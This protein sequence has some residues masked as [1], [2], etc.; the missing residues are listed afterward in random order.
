MA[1]SVAEIEQFTHAMPDFR[2]FWLQGSSPGGTIMMYGTTGF[3][4]AG[5][6]IPV[7]EWTVE[8]LPVISTIGELK[9]PQPWDMLNGSVT[10]AYNVRTGFPPGVTQ[11]DAWVGTTFHVWRIGDELRWAAGSSLI[12]LTSVMRHALTGFSVHGT[13]VPLS[14]TLSLFRSSAT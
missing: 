4:P 13:S 2:S 5:A 9:I 11:H 14:W 6:G 8:P 12:T 1:I 7:Q 10:D 3:I